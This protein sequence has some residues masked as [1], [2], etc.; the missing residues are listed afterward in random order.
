MISTQRAVFFNI[1]AGACM[2]HDVKFSHRCTN[3]KTILS[4]AH[5]SDTES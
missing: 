1:A 2:L 3:M 4:C 5:M